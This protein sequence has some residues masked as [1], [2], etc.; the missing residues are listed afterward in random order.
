[1]TPASRRDYTAA[2]P[3][4]DQALGFC[5]RLS[6]GSAARPSRWVFWAR[7]TQPNI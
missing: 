4:F 2:M 1:M 3:V 5:R 7:R 6:S